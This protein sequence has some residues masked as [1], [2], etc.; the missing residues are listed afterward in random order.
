MALGESN[1]YVT[2]TSRDSKRLN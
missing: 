2:M 1:G